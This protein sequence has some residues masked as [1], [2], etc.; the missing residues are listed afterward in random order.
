MKDRVDKSTGIVIRST[1][2][3]PKFKPTETLR[4]AKCADLQR[5]NCSGSSGNSSSKILA[6][7]C[8]CKKNSPVKSSLTRPQVIT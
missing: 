5:R 8:V 3:V 7:Q 2:D 1:E 4:L 6:S